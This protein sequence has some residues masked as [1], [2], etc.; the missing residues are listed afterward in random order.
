MDRLDLYIIHGVIGRIPPVK[1]GIDN[2]ILYQGLVPPY[3]LT[4]NINLCD[5]PHTLW[6]ELIDKQKDNICNERNQ[7]T[8]VEFEN[9]AINGSM[10]NYLLND[11]GYTEIDWKHHADVADWYRIHHGEVPSRI[12]KSK[13]LNLKGI[14]KFVFEIPLKKFLD[15]HHKIDPAYLK[16]YNFPLDTYLE[17][18]QKLLSHTNP[19]I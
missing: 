12:E 6:M 2:Q 4:Y 1:I 17:L 13:Y 9:V 10:M 14:Y 18:E 19:P 5:G 3:H 8:F 7:D 11:C 16:Y 15:T